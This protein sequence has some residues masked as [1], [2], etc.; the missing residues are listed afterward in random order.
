MEGGEGECLAAGKGRGGDT[1]YF[2][3]HTPRRP[4]D[5]VKTVG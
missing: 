3:T 2:I 1:F 4:I 5:A